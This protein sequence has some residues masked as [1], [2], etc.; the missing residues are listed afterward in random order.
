MGRSPLLIVQSRDC[1]RKSTT[2]SQ[3]LTLALVLSWYGS[4]RAQHA[5]APKLS[6]LAPP[7]EEGPFVLPAPGAL[8]EPV[9]GLKD[10]MRI[11]LWPL[12]GPRGL[13]RVY[14][15]YL[16]QPAHRVINF[17]AVEPIV[18]DTRVRGL[19]ELEKSTLDDEPG[20]WFCPSN[21][22]GAAGSAPWHPPR[23]ELSVDRDG[24]Q[25]LSVYFHVEAFKNG[26]RPIVQARFRADRPHEVELR[27]FATPDSAA[28]KSCILTATMGNYARLRMLNL[29]DEVVDSRR[30]WPDYKPEG[31]GFA[32]H[33]AFD[34]GRLHKSGD[35]VIVSALTDERDPTSAVY[36]PSVAR[37]WHYVGK[38]ALQYWKAEP[39]VGLVARVN[40]RVTYWA[41]NAPIPGGIS[42]ENFELEAPFQSGQSFL[43]GVSPAAYE[44]LDVKNAAD[45]RD[46]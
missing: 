6:E 4:A 33:V 11:G 44:L 28:M 17:I 3:I 16:G 10:G 26:A 2:V 36:D 40:G 34:V 18:D 43:F 8:S 27:T 12:P 24:H 23:G 41:S 14:T 31:W 22:R 9:W 5:A 30:L 20:K 37:H 13:I 21:T 42:F 45:S 38:P 35:Q 7:V 29:A 39:V 25:M 19:S 32:P 15:P 1:R 46:R